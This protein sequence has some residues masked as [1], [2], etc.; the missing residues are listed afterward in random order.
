MKYTISACSKVIFSCEVGE[1]MDKARTAVNS[2]REWN[3]W[4]FLE[5]FLSTGEE[6]RKDAA[7][8]SN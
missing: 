6:R 5:I 8:R 2:S 3:E 1:S 7:V 4:P